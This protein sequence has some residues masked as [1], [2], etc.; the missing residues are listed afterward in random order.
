[1]QAIEA[2]VVRPLIRVGVTAPMPARIHTVTTTPTIAF[3]DIRVH[4]AQ[5]YVWDKVIG[6]KTKSVQWINQ[7]GRDRRFLTETVEIQW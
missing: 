4:H 5:Q 1:M 6:A 3:F 2:F 7:V